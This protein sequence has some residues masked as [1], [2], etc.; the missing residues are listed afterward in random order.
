MNVCIYISASASTPWASVSVPNT[1]E[2]CG[3]HSYSM[4]VRYGEYQSCL[5]NQHEIMH[6][7]DRYDLVWT[8]DADCLI[9]NHNLKIEEV[10][11]LGNHCTVCE[12]GMP[13]LSW[14]R[15]NCGAIVYRST[16][17]TRKLLRAIHEAEPQWSNPSAYAFVWQSWLADHAERFSDCLT[18]LPP[19]SFNSVAWEQHG[20]GTT[21]ERGDF[22]FHPC[23]HPHSKREQ[24]L[25]DKLPEVMR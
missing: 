21:W 9:T 8:L 10:P 19:R 22:V 24:I 23:C 4:L 3:R 25:R 2:Y 11:G 6:L 14:N 17:P 15:L 13:W 7:L 20:G 1:F 18:I 16:E 12:E 5:R